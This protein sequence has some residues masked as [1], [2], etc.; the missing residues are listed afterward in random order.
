MANDII[1]DFCKESGVRLY[2]FADLV[3]LSE[4]WFSVHMRKEYPKEVQLCLVEA[5]KKTI[6]GEAYDLSAWN[7]WR[8]SQEVLAQAKRNDRLRKKSITLWE[9]RKRN[10]ALDEAE[11]RRIKGGWDTWQ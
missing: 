6:K 8:A 9:W 2:Q 5:M 11:E 3:G 1:R 4:N 10:A 7:D